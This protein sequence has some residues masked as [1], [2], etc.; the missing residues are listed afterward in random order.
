L[1]AKSLA[2]IFAVRRLWVDD[3][4]Q[5]NLVIDRMVATTISIIRRLEGIEQKLEVFCSAE[6]EEKSI[7]EPVSVQA[8]QPARLRRSLLDSVQVRRKRLCPD[9]IRITD[10]PLPWRDAFC[11]AIHD[12][13]RP[14]IT[15]EVDIS[16]AWDWRD[17]L[18]DKL[19]GAPK[20]SFLEI[21]EKSLPDFVSRFPPSAV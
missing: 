11:S 18:S 14:E 15:G 10:I 13:R 2:R 4:R 19:P 8:L 12:K 21:Y 16:Y 5:D 3:P 20:P 6:I 1:S 7:P 17:W 9:F